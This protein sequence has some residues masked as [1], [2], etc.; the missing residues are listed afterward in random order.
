MTVINTTGFYF[1]I[2]SPI[3][4]HCT[5]SLHFTRL[6][7]FLTHLLCM[8]THVGNTPLHL[9]AEKGYVDVINVL[10]TSPS[11]DVNLQVMKPI[12][13]WVFSHFITIF[14][15]KVYQKQ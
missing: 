6:L 9:S 4:V 12:H 10:L 2:E 13:L 1:V 3:N 5:I 15:H 11:C 7:L 8:C 14:S